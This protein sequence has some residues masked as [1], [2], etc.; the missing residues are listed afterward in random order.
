MFKY[1]NLQHPSTYLKGSLLAITEPFS[2]VNIIKRIARKLRRTIL[3]HFGL[4][5]FRIHFRKTRKPITFMVCGPSGR[6]HD[7]AKHCQTGE[8]S[9]QPSESN[10][11]GIFVL[12]HFILVARARSRGFM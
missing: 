5:T 12:A 11:V 4:V 8:A 9:N 7:S 6:E 1:G 2:I 3:R 10:R